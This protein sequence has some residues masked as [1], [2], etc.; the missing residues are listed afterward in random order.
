MEE[1]RTKI[2]HLDL[3]LPCYV[4]CFWHLYVDIQQ[5]EYQNE[6]K[7]FR[8][9]TFQYRCRLPCYVFCTWYLYDDIQQIEHQKENKAFRQ[10]TPFTYHGKS[11]YIYS[12][13][14]WFFEHD[15]R[16]SLFPREA[17]YDHTAYAPY[18]RYT[19]YNDTR[20]THV[21]IIPQRSQHNAKGYR[22][23]ETLQIQPQPMLVNCG[24]REYYGEVQYRGTMEVQWRASL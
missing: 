17:G 5:A 20:H 12:L 24:G 11:L 13:H 3:S 16:H 18:T 1:S 8:Q 10:R 6:N 14:K 7:A 21:M 22:S 15:W 4:F 19:R 2:R 9:Q 23:H